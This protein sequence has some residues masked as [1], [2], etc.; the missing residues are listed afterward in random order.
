MVNV[1]SGSISKELKDWNSIK[2]QHYG[3]KPAFILSSPGSVNQGDKE[4]WH[5][6]NEV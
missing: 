3:K 6:L 2:V 4:V 1:A 5:V